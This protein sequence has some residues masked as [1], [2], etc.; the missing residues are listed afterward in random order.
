MVPAWTG[1]Q[2]SIFQSGTFDQIEKIQ[3]FYPKYWKT[4]DFFTLQKWNPDYKS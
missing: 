3:E 2:D 4:Q 1:K